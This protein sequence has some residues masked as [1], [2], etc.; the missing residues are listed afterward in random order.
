MT[1]Q[2]ASFPTSN[3]L[4]RMSVQEKNPNEANLAAEAEAYMYPTRLRKHAANAKLPFIGLS[5]DV[6]Q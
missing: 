2:E 5:S 3:R 6:S 1:P 4:S